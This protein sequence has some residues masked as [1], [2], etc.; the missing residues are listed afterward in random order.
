M[1]WSASKVAES[2]IKVAEENGLL[3]CLFTGSKDGEVT[4]VGRAAVPILTFSTMSVATLF[5]GVSL[6]LP[7][8]FLY[9]VRGKKSVVFWR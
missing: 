8:Q 1:K 5:S 6:E 3:Q 2:R 9:F 7:S 4:N